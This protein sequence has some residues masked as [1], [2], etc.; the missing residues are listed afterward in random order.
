MRYSIILIFLSLLA[1]NATSAS[2][3]CSKARSKME[4]AVCS[5][6]ELGVLD[7]KLAASYGDLKNSFSK[8]FF[9]KYVKSNQVNWLKA[10]SRSFEESKK[11]EFLTK[12][13]QDRIKTLVESKKD[14]F[15]FKVFE[16]KIDTENKAIAQL[17]K[18]DRNNYFYTSLTPLSRDLIFVRM[19]FEK[20][21][22]P[23]DGVPRCEGYN[24]FYRISTNKN[25]QSADLFEPNYLSAI[26]SLI[27]AQ[28]KSDFTDYDKNEAIENIVIDLSGLNNLLIDGKTLTIDHKFGQY[29]HSCAYVPI[30][31]K[32][33][34]I[35][36][37]LKNEFAKELG[38]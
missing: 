25:L 3:D 12:S 2:F 30:S 5:S 33:S 10:T 32:I 14:K 26:A 24:K 7:E 15:G 18:D 31:I 36:K 38:F 4:K 22:L 23:D 28:N 34:E 9:A 27:Y 20:P 19:S 6:D 16:G 1:F 8:D 11:I 29:S 17:Q 13:Y 37:Y 21:S 35:K